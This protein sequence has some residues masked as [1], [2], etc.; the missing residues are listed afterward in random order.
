MRERKTEGKKGRERQW[1]AERE[2][3][4]ERKR[5]KGR[6]ETKD[7]REVRNRSTKGKRESARQRPSKTG[8]RGDRAKAVADTERWKE[9]ALL[10][11]APGAIRA[12]RPLPAP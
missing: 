4:G 12:S 10:S 2:T 11:D 8:R 7:T 3:E 1:E 9:T 6:G 5:K